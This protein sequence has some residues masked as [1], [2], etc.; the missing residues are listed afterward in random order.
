MPLSSRGENASQITHPHACREV[1]ACLPHRRI[2]GSWQCSGGTRRDRSM[3]SAFV[4]AAGLLARRRWAPAAGSGLCGRALVVPRASGRPSGARV[5]R[6][7]AK[8]AEEEEGV[9]D[10]PA[11]RAAEIHEVLNGLLEF[12][13]RIVDGTRVFCFCCFSVRLATYLL[14]SS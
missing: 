5:V 4:P 2:A 7:V 3:S 13:G 14:C 11:M 12:K 6:A 10:E 1:A 8:G 9:L